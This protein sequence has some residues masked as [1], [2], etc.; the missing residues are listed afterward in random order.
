VSTGYFSATAYVDDDVRRYIILF[1]FRGER[2]QHVSSAALVAVVAGFRSFRFHFYYYY[3]LFFLI[4]HGKLSLPAKVHSARPHDDTPFVVHPRDSRS[5]HVY[6]FL[7]ASG[8]SKRNV[9]RYKT[10]YLYTFHIYIYFYLYT[11]LY[12]YII[13]LYVAPRRVS[14]RGVKQIKITH[15]YHREFRPR[16]LFNQRH[17]YYFD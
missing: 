12:G 17:Y 9:N 16:F 1:Y 8:P 15:T 13:L 3:F 7:P 10:F 11:C 5:R 4:P 6:A 2:H 14:A